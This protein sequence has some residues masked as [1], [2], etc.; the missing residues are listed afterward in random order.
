MS[1]QAF[2]T[3]PHLG[4]QFHP[5]ATGP[6]MEAWISSITP[7]PGPGLAS[8]LRHGW[9]QAA[10]VVAGNAAT[11]FSSWLEGDFADAARI[12]VSLEES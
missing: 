11:L 6:I 1:V 9:Q 2:A 3:G 7:A 8:Q 4:L 10:G 12:P 5:E